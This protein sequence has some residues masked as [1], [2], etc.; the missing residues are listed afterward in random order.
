MADEAA[1]EH[2]EAV[3][4]D[5]LLPPQW[6]LAAAQDLSTLPA[7]EFAAWQTEA[8]IPELQLLL[9][10]EWDPDDQRRALPE[11]TEAYYATAHSV[12]FGL[13]MGDSDAATVRRF[14]SHGIRGQVGSPSTTAMT[15]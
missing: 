2:L 10:F 13:W 4:D 1:R 5:Q 15:R 9:L 8:G 7:D 6:A 3:D 12:L 14:R 11:S